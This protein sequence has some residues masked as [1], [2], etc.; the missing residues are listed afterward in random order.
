MRV[1]DRRRVNKNIVSQNEANDQIRLFQFI[2][3]KSETYEVFANITP[4]ALKNGK[5]MK[6]SISQIFD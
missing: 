2:L 1:N 3:G 6:S 4:T 5:T